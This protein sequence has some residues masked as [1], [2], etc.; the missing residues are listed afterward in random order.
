MFE[1][2]V[3]TPNGNTET[4]PRA[5]SESE[6]RFKRSER[7]NTSWLVYM[8]IGISRSLGGREGCTTCDLTTEL[9]WTIAV[10]CTSE[11][12]MMIRLPGKLQYAWETRTNLGRNVHGIIAVGIICIGWPIP[13]WTSIVQVIEHGK[14]VDPAEAIWK[15]SSDYNHNGDKSSSNN[16][17][18]FQIGSQLL[19]L[20]VRNK[21]RII[22]ATTDDTVPVRI[23]DVISLRMRLN[24]T[25]IWMIRCRQSS[26]MGGNAPLSSFEGRLDL[27][28]LPE[29]C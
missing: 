29:K 5:E 10:R 3:H 9:P 6:S 4:F 25:C 17:R 21:I 2:L 24:N 1:L 16:L 26:I 23:V 19:C 7:S 15:S 27:I 28:Q 22:T 18:C 8:P 20:S 12:W 13:E 11:R 14:S